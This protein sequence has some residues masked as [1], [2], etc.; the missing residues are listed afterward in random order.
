MGQYFL[1]ICS[2]VRY[3][4]LKPVIKAMSPGEGHIYVFFTTYTDLATSVEQL[5][6]FIYFYF[7]M[8]AY[9]LVQIY[10]HMYAFSPFFF[11]PFPLIYYILTIGTDAFN[12]FSFYFSF[13]IFSLFMN[14]CT[15]IYAMVCLHVIFC[16]R[17]LNFIPPSFI[18]Y[19]EAPRSDIF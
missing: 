9:R 17:V 4:L 2:I 7:H 19:T 13:Y 11:F 12:L 15:F 10:I 3:W 14:G 6:I 16:C 1:T 18:D 5:N 8:W